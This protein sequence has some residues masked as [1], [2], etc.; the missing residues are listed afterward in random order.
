MMSR[1]LFSA[2]VLSSALAYGQLDSNSI[3]V[4]ASR[5]VAVQ[6]DLVVLGVSVSSGINTSLDDVLNALAGSGITRMNFSGVSST[7]TLS[8][9]G[10]PSLPG[11]L[12]APQPP[13]A[14]N[15]TLPVSLAK[16]KD[17]LATLTALQKTITQNNS[18]L[19]LSFTV[20]G[21]Q[22]SPQLQQMQTCSVADLLSDA[23]TEAQKLANAA[24][25]FLGSVLAMSSLTASN[26][27]SINIPGLSFSPPSPC[28]LTVKFAVT[29]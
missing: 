19:T 8:F 7:P 10:F 9:T 4:T 20:Q 1:S 29:R 14:W 6:P 15:F 12:P 28:T 2:F 23:R 18:G 27:P 21:T 3:T 5:S 25:L 22:V 13:L 17:T 24:N 11:I 16:M 26:V